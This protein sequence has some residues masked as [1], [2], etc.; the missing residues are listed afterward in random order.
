MTPATE[1]DLAGQRLLVVGA[2]SGIGRSL[3]ALAAKAGA[4][5]VATARRADRLDALCA[6]AGGQLIA[7]EGDARRDADCAAMVGRAVSEFGGLDALIYAAGVSSLSP[8]LETDGEAWRSILGTNVIGPALT[9]QAALPHLLESNGRAVFLSSVS[10]ADPRPMIVPYGA[11]K[12]ALDALIQGWRNEHPDIAFIRI[13]VGPTSTEF[14]SGWD[15]SNIAKL[16]EARAR[17]GLLRVRRMTSDQCAKAILDTLT[18]PIWI[19][20]IKLMP[21]NTRTEG[22]VDA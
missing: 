10:A 17:M 19:E 18:A 9:C 12:A 13:G 1:R 3:A 6:E 20:D 11:S 7:H 8:L 14:G 5:V 4:R 21:D 16:T 2:S 22:D 15:R